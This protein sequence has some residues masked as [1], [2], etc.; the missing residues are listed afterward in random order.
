MPLLIV[1]RLI[2][3]PVNFRS[4]SILERRQPCLIVHAKLLQIQPPDSISPAYLMPHS[5]TEC[6][7]NATSFISCMTLKKT[8]VRRWSQASDRSIYRSWIAAPLALT[9]VGTQLTSQDV[10]EMPISI[11]GSICAYLAGSFQTY[12]ASEIWNELPARELPVCTVQWQKNET[13]FL[14]QCNDTDWLPN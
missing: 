13:L 5:F 4:N 1:S 2:K 3:R 6:C 7:W 9:V 11:D 10:L 14:Y 8:S 12:L